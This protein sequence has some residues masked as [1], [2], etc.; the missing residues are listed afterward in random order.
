VL[1]FF[2][3]ASGWGVIVIVEIN[4]AEFGMYG[5]VALVSPLRGSTDS[6]G[7][8]MLPI[9]HPTG[10]CFSLN[11]IYLSNFQSYYKLNFVMVCGNLYCY[12]NVAD[13]VCVGANCIRP[14]TYH[15]CGNRRINGNCYLVD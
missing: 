6:R 5:F 10:F 9:F 2:F 13:V 4:F 8:C 12:S 15:I 3:L 11:G 14:Y 7:W 1:G